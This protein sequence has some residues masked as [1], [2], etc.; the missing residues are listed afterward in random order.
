MAILTNVGKSIIGW[1]NPV[2]IVKELATDTQIDWIDLH[3]TDKDGLWEEYQDE[4]LEH[5]LIN[6]DLI[7]TFK[8]RRFYFTLSYAAAP[9][10]EAG[11]L[12]HLKIQRLLNWQSTNLHYFDIIPRYD[13]GFRDRHFPVLKDPGKPLRLGVKKGGRQNKGNRGVILYFKS[14]HLIQT[15]DWR[16]PA[17]IQFG[18]F[19]FTRFFVRNT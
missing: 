16:D 18:N 19:Y 13:P 2:I 12:N 14:I 4:V 6:Y 7:H 17:N 1:Q 9:T 11:K 10:G 3:L 8:G 5:E 15:I